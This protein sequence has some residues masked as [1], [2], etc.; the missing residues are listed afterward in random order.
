MAKQESLVKLRGKIGDLSFSKHRERGYEVRM[1]GGVD[2]Q[3]ILSDPKFQRTRENM[4]EFGAAAQTAKI[5]RLQLNNLLRG[6]ADKDF[7]NRLTSVVH[8]IQKMDSESV[9]GERVFKPENSY[10]LKGL[11]F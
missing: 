7:R 2:K 11:E 3:R 10:L 1:K 6:V 8:R 4:T 9:R 5:I